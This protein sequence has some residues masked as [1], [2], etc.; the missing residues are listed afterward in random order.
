MGTNRDAIGFR[1]VSSPGLELA[2]RG[3]EVISRKNYTGGF[4]SR[5]GNLGGVGGSA[6]TSPTVDSPLF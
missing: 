6:P 3:H 5:L 2:L 1:S 4:F